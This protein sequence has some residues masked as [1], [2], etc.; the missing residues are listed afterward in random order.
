VFL[1]LTI[2]YVPRQ[3]CH[4]TPPNRSFAWSSYFMCRTW[5]FHSLVFFALVSLPLACRH[6]ARLSSLGFA[7]FLAGI[8]FTFRLKF[9]I[10]GQSQSLLPSLAVWVA[11]GLVLANWDSPSLHAPLTCSSLFWHRL[12]VL[13]DLGDTKA[14][15]QPQAPFFS[16]CP[17][18]LQ[19]HSHPLDH[20]AGPFWT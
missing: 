2:P 13:P 5:L 4:I 16:P 12:Y 7:F 17:R 14:P 10:H 11:V 20:C 18:V 8:F 9:F 6:M 19:A 3:S 1:T 15:T